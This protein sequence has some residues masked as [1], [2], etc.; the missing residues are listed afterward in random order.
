MSGE[1]AKRARNS[2][3]DFIAA[4]FLRGMESPAIFGTLVSFARQL[5]GQASWQISQPKMYFDSF[6]ACLIFGGIFEIGDLFS[7]VW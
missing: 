3:L 6:I 1:P 7:I 2:S 4:I 5:C